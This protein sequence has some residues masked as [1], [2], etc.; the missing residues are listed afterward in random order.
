MNKRI[1]GFLVL[2]LVV[3]GIGVPLVLTGQKEKNLTPE[4]SKT[5]YSEE[6][7]GRLDDAD[8][9]SGAE[10]SDQKEGYI[11]A[12]D[13]QIALIRGL[14]MPKPDSRI[15]AIQKMEIQ[16]ESLKRSSFAPSIANWRYLGPSPIPVSSPTSGRVSAI[17][18]HPTNPDI[19]Y[20]GAAQGGLYRTLNGGVTWTP[21]LD[22]AL[23]LAMG[24]VAISPS[25]PTTVY[26]GTGEAGASQD[27]FF[28]VGIYRI[29]NADTAPVVSAPIGGAEFTGRSISE[30]LVHPTDANTIFV[31]TT[32]GVCGLGSCTGA[33]APTQ[34]IYRSTNG[35]SATPTFTRILSGSVMDMVIE[36]GVPDTL[37]C[38][39]RGGVGTGGIYRTTNALSATPTFT[40]SYAAITNSSRGELA[41]QKTGV[42]VT[43][44]AATGEI[45]AGVTQGAVF[46]S[47]DGGLTFPTQLTGGNNFCASQCFYDIAVAFDPNNANNLY[48]AGSPQAVFRRSINGG[49]SFSSSAGGLHVD[50]HAITVAPSNPNIVYYGSDGGIYRTTN[51]TAT[52]IVW[53]SLNN[54]TFAA[55]QF[56][57]LALHPSLTNYTLGGTQDNGTLFLTNDGTTWVNSDGGDGGYV[58]ID[59]NSV[60]ISNVVAYHTYFNQ[61]NS[62]I[63]YSKA[64]TTVPANGDPNWG[65][66]LGCSNGVSNNGIACADSTL[67][68]A[69][70]VGGPGTPTNSLYF[71]TNK[72]YR[73]GD[74]GVT[75]APV[76]QTFGT[77]VSTIGISKQNDNVRIV[78]L[79][80]GTVFA[81]TTGSATMTQMIGGFPS[82][83]VGR[84]VI[85]PSNVNTAYVTFNGYGVAA[86]QHVFKTTNL[87]EAT[88]T[89]TP[90][91]NGIPDVPVNAFA[92][93]PI[94]S[95][96]L[97]AGTDIGVYSSTNGGANW[98]PINNSQLPRVAVFDM[99]IQPTSRIL[100]IATHGR[101][102]WEYDLNATAG[103]KYVDFDG[104]GKTD[105]SVFRPSVGEW[106]FQRSSNSVVNGAQFGS[107]T[108]QPAP[109]D[110]TGDGKTD[111]AF[112]R[113]STGQWFVLRSEDSSFFAFPFGAVG[114]IPSPGDFDGDGK[115]D[116]AV[117]RPSNGV[118]YINKSTGGVTIQP[119][120][121][122]NDRPTVADYDGDGKSDIAIF[123]PSVGEWYYLRS[124]DSQVR[125]AQF[126]AGTDR[127]VQGDYT[128]DGKA[129]FAFFRP[130]TGQWFVLRSEDS[131]FFA[132]PF[133]ISTDIPTIGDFDGDGKFDQ[134]VFRPSNGVWYVN[135]S[136]A[137][138]QIQQFGVGTDLPVPSYYLP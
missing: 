11:Q 10:D 138:V 123:R 122:N 81:T 107:S 15:K 43:V 51:V 89:W 127:T 14:P 5:L 61:T 41:I 71:G 97:F 7:E 78:G 101:G 24:A 100:R 83:F 37:L 87:N 30:I 35:L 34:G 64:T 90:A 27:S 32:T 19:A 115:A 129:D 16:E 40:Q 125:G 3:V 56:Q 112:W 49:T 134:A 117:F 126:G 114:D 55:T 77:V 105:I 104:D 132:S 76:S 96:N 47:I 60:G 75:M 1:L 50:T 26:V 17:A 86:G 108:D 4:P 116:Q 119:F 39:V 66:F 128:G 70:M 73:S 44:V 124:T 23:T 109:A 18:V 42:D 12:R 136:T 120:G 33:P 45:P 9:P 8:Y 25:D 135:R 85:D 88:P 21:L 106:Y 20:V 6:R 133:G 63:G 59:Q 53:N 31:S 65:G 111:I 110:Y 92:V 52:P 118:W 58:V 57:A 137:G 102:I 130:S 79:A 72:L 29:T 69:P 84:A 68:Y 54:S 38:W 91:G 13:E 95:N 36:P 46:K 22:G 94:N 62:Q 48:L 2:A 28:G 80:N 113:P 121:T 131:S 93:D 103:Q 99:S 74:Q 67:F 82:R 98:V